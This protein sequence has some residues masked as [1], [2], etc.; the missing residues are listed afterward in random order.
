MKVRINF[1]NLQSKILKCCIYG[2][3]KRFQPRIRIITVITMSDVSQFRFSVVCDDGVWEARIPCFVEASWL[4]L[5]DRFN[6]TS[7][8][9]IS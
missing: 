1:N 9:R 2:L 4:E 6:R 8:W 7:W 5:F 3:R